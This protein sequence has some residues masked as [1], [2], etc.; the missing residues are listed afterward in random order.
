MRL[1]ATDRLHCQNPPVCRECG[2]FLCLNGQRLVAMVA[3]PSGGWFEGDEVP[4]GCAGCLDRL[5]GSNL[6]YCN[7]KSLLALAVLAA[8]AAVIFSYCTAWPTLA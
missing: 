7:E 3:S 1:Q 6:G 5:H 8:G 2:I 4:F